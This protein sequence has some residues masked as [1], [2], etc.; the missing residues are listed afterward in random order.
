[1][2]LLVVWSHSFALHQGS[3]KNEP[4]SLLLNGAYNSGNIAVM[5][6]F[7]ISGFLITQ[8][9][10]SSRSTWWFMAKRVRRIYPGYLVATS[11]CAFVIVPLFS[12][13]C[14]LSALEVAKT[15]GGNLLLRN[16]FPPSNIF[17]SNAVPLALNGSLW[18]IP[19]EFWCYIGVAALG[20]LGLISRRLLIASVTA[21]ILLGR[22]ALDIMDKK[23]GGGIVGLI[24][25]WPYMWFKIL[26]SFMLGMAGYAFRDV[27]PRRRGVLIVL[28]VAAA[29]AAHSNQ[30]MANL[31]VAPALAYCLFYFAFSPTLQLHGAAKWGDFSYGTYLYAF[32]IQQMMFALWGT[33]ISLAG[34]I[35]LSLPLSLVAGI[36]SWYLVERWF[37]RYAVKQMPSMPQQDTFVIP[38]EKPHRCQARASPG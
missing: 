32:P 23:P 15:I 31:L 25:G 22:V 9:F 21:G 6:F 11:I 27:L 16:H 12:G 5:A 8:S 33:D 7:V 13:V 19:V 14:D 10:A 3:E 38:S 2:A 34:F 30:H 4:L 29:I 20:L 1:M 24:I 28:V 37:L 18:S 36:C 35:G 17:Y 26:P